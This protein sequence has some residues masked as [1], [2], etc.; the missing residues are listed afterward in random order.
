MFSSLSSKQSIKRR[1]INPKITNGANINNPILTKDIVTRNAIN[2]AK[3]HIDI[4]ISNAQKNTFIFYPLID[5]MGVKVT[6]IS[7]KSD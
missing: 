6:S 2:G 1:I 7:T 5:A 4:T 3:I